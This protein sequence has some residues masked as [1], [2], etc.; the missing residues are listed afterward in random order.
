MPASELVH[1]EATGRHSVEI[2]WNTYAHV[3]PDMQ[4]QAAATMGAILHAVSNP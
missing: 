3:L 1:G 2:T 4:Q